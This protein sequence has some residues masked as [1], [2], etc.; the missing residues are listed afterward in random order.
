MREISQ[1]SEIV[2]TFLIPP[3]LSLF[4]WEK[5]KMTADG[6]GNDPELSCFSWYVQS[7]RLWVPSLL[8]LSHHPKRLGTIPSKMRIIYNLALTAAQ[9]ENM[10]MSSLIN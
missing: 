6:H 4:D 1:P 8:S 2:F 10:L 3:V 9:Q 5:K 7:F